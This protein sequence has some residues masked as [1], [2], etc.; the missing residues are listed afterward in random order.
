VRDESPILL[1]DVDGVISLWGFDNTDPPP[2]R[3]A[4]IDG[5]AHYL[6]STAAGH[7]KQLVSQHFDLVWCTGWEE[8]ADEHLPHLLGLPAGKAHLTFDGRSQAEV[9]TH[10]HWK[11]PAI[12]AFVGQRAIAWI[13]DALDDAC[14]S[15]ADARQ[16]PTL[17]VD[18]DPAVGLDERGA[19]V[20]N[21]FARAI[22]DR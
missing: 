1:C 14:R 8:R 11:L 3:W 4:Q 22:L 9:S 18:T 16:W 21:A 15:W 5:T 19:D 2:G 13:D 12:D 6:S 20:L 7:I 17:L 10:G